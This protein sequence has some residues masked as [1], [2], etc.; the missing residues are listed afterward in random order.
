MRYWHENI[1]CPDDGAGDGEVRALHYIVDKPWEK[2]IASD[3]VAGHLGRDG[4]THGWWWEVWEE[5]KRGRAGETELLEIVEQDV[6]GELDEEGDRRRCEENREKGLPVPVPDHPGM[7]KGVKD[8]GHG[9]LHSGPKSTS[10]RP[11]A[12]KGHGR[13]VFHRAEE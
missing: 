4:V 12:E 2:R 3:G 9:I 10:T 8:E 11:A 5:W 6:D 13:V 1:W 7:R